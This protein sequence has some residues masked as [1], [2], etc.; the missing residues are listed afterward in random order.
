MILIYNQTDSDEFIYYFKKDYIRTNTEVNIKIQNNYIEKLKKPYSECDKQTNEL[1]DMT[2]LRVD[3]KKSYKQK[4]CLQKAYRYE[5]YKICKCASVVSDSYIPDTATLCITKSQTDC[6]QRVFDIDYLIRRFD[7]LYDKLCP[8]ECNSLDY[9]LSGSSQYFPPYAY[10]KW[11]L[12]NN[13][14]AGSGLLNRSLR[15]EDISHNVARVNIFYP[16]LGYELITEIEAMTLINL[17]ANTGGM[18]GLFMGMSFLSFVELIEIVSEIVFIL[19]VRVK[20][21]ISTFVSYYK[22][23]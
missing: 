1:E 14:F 12:R 15:I 19:F 2:F 4:F 13:K 20:S 21:D 7:G 9:Q 16:K 17:L 23:L 6:A 18:L 10:S 5:V 11:L 8:L 3:D 22:W